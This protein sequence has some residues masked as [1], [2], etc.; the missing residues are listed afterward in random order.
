MSQVISFRL[1]QNNP[2]EAWA[3]SVLSGMQEQ[4]YQVRHILT[5]ALV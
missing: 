4:G 3:L 2:R 5:E 1:D